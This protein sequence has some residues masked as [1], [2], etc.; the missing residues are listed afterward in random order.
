MIVKDLYCPGCGKD[1]FGVVS[2]EDEGGY[3][4]FECE[5]CGTTFGVWLQVETVRMALMVTD[6]VPIKK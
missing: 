4:E 6:P 2:I 1:V 3:R 5:H